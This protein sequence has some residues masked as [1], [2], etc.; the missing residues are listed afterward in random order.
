MRIFRLLRRYWQNDRANVLPIFALSVIPIFGLI[1][2]AVDFSRAS[3]VK[4]SMQAS[5]DATGLMLAKEVTSL[6]QEQ[7]AQKADLYFRS[8][9]NRPEAYQIQVTPVLTTLPSGS[10]KLEVAATAIVDS[11]F[12]RVFWQ[13]DISINTSTEVVWGAKKLE[14]ALA[15]DNTGSMAYSNKLQELKAAARNLLSTLRTSATNPG[16]VKVSII[17]FTTMVRLDAATYRSKP[18]YT[19]TPSS[20]WPGCVI[21][22]NQN[23]DVQ[24]NPPNT[25]DTKFPISSSSCSLA[26]SMPLTDNWTALNNKIDAMQAV[27]ATNVTIG[28]V[29]AWHSL[30]PGA[31][32]TEGSAPSPDIEKVI[33][34]LT[35][36]EN[37][38]NRWWGNGYDH[39]TQVD[40]R[41]QLVCNNIKAA[42]IKIYTIRVIEGNADLLRNCATNTNMY[43]DVQ[44]ASQLNAVFSAI[45]DQL[46]NLRISK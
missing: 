44:Q 18:W 29:W 19:S 32:Y 8:Q 14:L 26:T 33:I 15:L 20:S 43:F 4:A 45:G 11:T 31:P 5:L 27:G 37:T 7:L 6:T 34:A 41:T 46:A 21:D 24:D 25:T 22:R 10:K 40:G 30:T 38:K 13:P 16:D 35:D 42:G 12:T 36:G 39:N 28:L 1:G 17:P 23:Y 3:S 9:F 2:A